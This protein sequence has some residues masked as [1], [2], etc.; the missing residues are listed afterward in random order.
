MKKGQIFG[1]ILLFT[2]HLSAISAQNAKLTGTV[3]DSLGNPVLFANVK[4]KNTFF[5]AVTDFNGKYRLENIPPGTYTVLVNEMGFKPV[6]KDITL[7][8]NQALVSD[9]EL[10]PVQMQEVVIK[11][12]VSV[13]G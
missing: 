3:K 5:V 13:N 1:I 7:A 11:G 6:S 4:I 2:L 9:F 12:T 10:F 8:E